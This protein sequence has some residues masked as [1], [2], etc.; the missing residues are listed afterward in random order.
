ME[1]KIGQTLP[2]IMREKRLSVKELC[3]KSGVPVSTL[4]EWMNGR[5][6]RD[7]VQ[8]KKVADVL[9]ISLNR[10]LF[11]E[12]DFGESINLTQMLKEDVFNGTFEINIKRVKVKSE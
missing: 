7:P 5:T 3:K 4:H 2:R 1:L 8:A 9:G 10:L 12:A 11:D 6:P